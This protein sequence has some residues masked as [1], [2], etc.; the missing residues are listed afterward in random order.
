MCVNHDGWRGDLDLWCT[1]AVMKFAVSFSKDTEAA[2]VVVVQV[3]RP[4]ICT[5]SALKLPVMFV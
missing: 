2:V 5:S 4:Q 1:G 3:Q